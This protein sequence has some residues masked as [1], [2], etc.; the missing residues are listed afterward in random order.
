MAANG[1]DPVKW[2]LQENVRGEDGRMR[3]LARTAL[4]TGLGI[5]DDRAAADPAGRPCFATVLQQFLDQAS[6]ATCTLTRY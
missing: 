2:V 3:E 1:L 4:D 5:A 6:S